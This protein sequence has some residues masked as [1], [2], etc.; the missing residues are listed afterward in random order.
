MFKKLN[1]LK[2]HLILKKAL[3]MK[4]SQ[5]DTSDD[6]LFFLTKNFRKSV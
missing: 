2:K 5:I 6:F 4:K 1:V 3:F